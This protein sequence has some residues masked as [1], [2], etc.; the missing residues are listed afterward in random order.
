MLVGKPPLKQRNS[1]ATWFLGVPMA[2]RHVWT[3]YCLELFGPSVLSAAGGSETGVAQT[4]LLTF[5]AI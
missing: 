5:L 4:T 1:I 2:L 3:H